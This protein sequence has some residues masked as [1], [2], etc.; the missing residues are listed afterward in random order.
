VSTVLQPFRPDASSPWDADAAAHLWRRAGFGASPARIEATVRLDPQEAARSLVEGPARDS[1]AEGLESIF[2]AVVGSSD[3]DK[4]RAWLVSR[5]IRCEHQ[6]REKVALFWHGHFA[7]SIAK[8]RDLG[9]MMRQYRIFLEEGLGRFPA[10]LA[11]VARDPAMLRW[12]DNETN[13]KGHPNENF[14]RELFELFTLGVGNYGEQDIQEAARA[15]TGWHILQDEYRF[16]KALHDEGEKTVFG[17]RGRFGGDD[18]LALALEHPACSRFLARKLLDFFVMPVPAGAASE[19]VESV[20]RLLRD[21]GYDI[22][23][24]LRAL[25]GSQLF[26]GSAARRSLVKSPLDYFVG[27]ARSLEMPADATAAVPLLRE[28]GQ[29]LLSPP[30]VKGWPGHGAW[31]NTATWITR[32][33][34]A[35]RIAATLEIGFDGEQALDHYGRA[36]LGRPPPAAERQ[37]LLS[38]GTGKRDL[39]HGLLAL[40]EAHLL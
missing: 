38:A 22:G 19:E 4:A 20:A 36:L 13:S 18:V 10:L 25:F 12:L 33:N 3:D 15:F 16:S 5:M 28:M 29:D 1:A 9:W 40:P 34:A 21:T 27:A 14:A 31:I 32:V 24:T 7:T 26:Y 39:V 35:E 23:A 8:V 2:G 37:A 11:R 30:N 6:L 17:K